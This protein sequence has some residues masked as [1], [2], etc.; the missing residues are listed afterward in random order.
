MVY[1]FQRVMDVQYNAG[2][3]FDKQ[4][5]NGRNGYHVSGLG[6]SIT[7]DSR[8]NAFSP[9]RGMLL[10]F[11]F[12]HFTPA[13]GSDYQYT[14]FVLDLRQFIRLFRRQVLAFQVYGLYN[15]G[16]V[17]LR[18]LAALGGANSLRGYYEGRYRDKNMTAIQAEY[19]IPIYRRLGAVAFGDIGNAGPELVDINFQC[20]KYSYGTGLRIALN[21]TEKLNLR[22]DYGI[23]RGTSHGFYLQLGEAF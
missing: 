10:Q 19:R 1:Q 18:S 13:L 15:T 2:G 3:L 16:D 12:D 21:K 4:N 6:L 7:Y 8:N 11:Y 9:D 20:L 22:L 17:P 23:G 5:I 14:S